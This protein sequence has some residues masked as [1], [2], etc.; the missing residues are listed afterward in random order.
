MLKGFACERIA[1][2]YN[3]VT[4]VISMGLVQQSLLLVSRCYSHPCSKLDL[5]ALWFGKMYLFF[6]LA[7]KNLS[8]SVG[9][10]ESHVFTPFAIMG[11]AQLGAAFHPI[12]PSTHYPPPPPPPLALPSHPHSPLLPPIFSI[13]PVTN[14]VD[15]LCSVQWPLQLK[16]MY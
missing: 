8:L 1:V 13:T 7:L 9:N 12:S 15:P 6:P 10:N 4:S 11:A 14:P 2:L 16:G 5:L 3:G